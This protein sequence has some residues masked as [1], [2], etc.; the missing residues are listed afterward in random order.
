MGKEPALENRTYVFCL[1]CLASVW[2]SSGNQG[3]R[4]ETCPLENAELFGMPKLL[5]PFFIPRSKS[6]YCL[7]SP[8]RDSGRYLLPPCPL[9]NSLLE[10]VVR[11]GESGTK[12]HPRSE[13]PET[14]SSWFGSFRFVCQVSGDLCRLLPETP[15]R[16][17]KVISSLSSMKDQAENGIS[18]KRLHIFRPWLCQ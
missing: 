8:L 15:E 5:L 2:S 17:C 6:V 13:A 12:P 16:K 10:K 18:Q 1:I 14:L 4:P 3:T 11:Q 7:T 9:R